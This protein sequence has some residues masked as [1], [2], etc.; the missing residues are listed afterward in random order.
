MSD[1]KIERPEAPW[2]VMAEEPSGFAVPNLDEVEEEKEPDPP[3]FPTPGT[4]SSGG[5]SPGYAARP[6]LQ[7]SGPGSSAQGYASPG[8]VGA[9]GAAV[10]S[11][12]TA[13]K[14]PTP[15]EIVHAAMPAISA[16]YPHI[17]KAPYTGEWLQVL[18]IMISKAMEL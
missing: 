17:M 12:I 6:L 11:Q 3:K 5:F 2:N 8:Y 18:A 13:K 1:K 15:Q 16:S 9:Y 10:T 7:T 4:V 14:P